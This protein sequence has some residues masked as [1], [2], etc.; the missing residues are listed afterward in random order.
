[1]P[2]NRGVGMPKANKKKVEQS[3]EAFEEP[4]ALPAASEPAAPSTPDKK[5]EKRG[6]PPASPGMKA[7]QQAAY[8]AKKAKRVAD[9]AELM[10]LDA[11]IKQKEG[12]AQLV[13]RLDGQA[14]SLKKAKGWDKA[15]VL[16]RMDKAELLIEQQRVKSLQAQLLACALRVDAKDAEIAEKDAC[17]CRLKRLLR[18]KKEQ[19]ARGAESHV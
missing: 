1:M 11:Q 4:P 2:R 12:F 14:R 13:A 8:A 16:Q 5:Q 10:S 17:A 15:F 19:C 9:K 3:S 18:V 7:V 6:R